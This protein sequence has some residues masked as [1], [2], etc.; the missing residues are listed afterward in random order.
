MLIIIT[1]LA[2]GGVG[3]AVWLIFVALA[4]L[5]P[6]WLNNIA[7]AL[8]IGC[9]FVSIIASLS[10][11]VTGLVILGERIECRVEIAQYYAVRD[12]VAMAR[13]SGNEAERAA[14][15]H[16]II[17]T[18]QW[19]AKAQYYRESLWLNWSCD[20]AVEELEPLK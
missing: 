9:L 7:A 6:E 1:L 18:N 5:E 14:L 15:Q 2:I 19:L 13:E 17:E 4:P 3:V 12:A 11:A 20:P 8:A 16:K 10:A